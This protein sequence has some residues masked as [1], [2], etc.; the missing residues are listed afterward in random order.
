MFQ[1]K[2][3]Y[4]LLL[5][6][7]LCMNINASMNDDKM[8]ALQTKDVFVFNNQETTRSFIS[9]VTIDGINYLIKQKKSLSKQFLV[10]RDALAAWIAEDLGIAHSVYIVPSHKKLPGKKNMVWPA[11]LLTI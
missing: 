3:L 11:V 7:L 8:A 4:S 2:Y 9:Y 6:S 10:V 5:L 1:I